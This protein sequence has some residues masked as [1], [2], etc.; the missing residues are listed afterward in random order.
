MT[1]LES[2]VN[3]FYNTSKEDTNVIEKE[4]PVVEEEF[5]FADSTSRTE[6][7][8]LLR[9][10]LRITGCGLVESGVNGEI[11]I[12]DGNGQRH[13][14]GQVVL[15]KWDGADI[16]Q[17]KNALVV[18]GLSEASAQE[19]A[20]DVYQIIS[21]TNSYFINSDVLAV[22]LLTELSEQQ[23]SEFVGIIRQM[24]SFISYQKVASDTYL[25]KALAIK[26]YYFICHA[27]KLIEI[28][29]KKNCSYF[30][31]KQHII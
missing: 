8:G 11:I 3:S 12:I 1:Y 22:V 18:S 27:L 16:N 9:R 26:C 13:E 2:Y 25:R 6:A 30:W 4:E 28:T 20:N 24:C 14:I 15:S 23:K 17:V 19:F 5:L 10:L 29:F 31:Y 21:S 7:E